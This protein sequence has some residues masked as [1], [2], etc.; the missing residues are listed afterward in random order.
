MLGLGKLGSREMTV[1]SDLDLILIYDAPD[2]VE[3]SDG[4][5]AAAA[6]DLLRAA[7]RSASSTR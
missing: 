6:F 2:A 5:A 3:A 1:T 7:E 4:R